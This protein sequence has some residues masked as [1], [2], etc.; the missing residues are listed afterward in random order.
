MAKK[1]TSFI[2]FDTVQIVQ[3]YTFMRHHHMTASGCMFHLA[4]GVLNKNGY[5]ASNFE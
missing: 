4:S 2:A 1:M 3:C 5:F